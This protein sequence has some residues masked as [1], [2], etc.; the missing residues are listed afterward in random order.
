VVTES[1][2][3]DE[4]QDLDPC[5]YQSD[6]SDSDPHRSEKK[7]PDPRQ[8][9]A[10]PKNRI[11]LWRIAIKMRYTVLVAHKWSADKISNN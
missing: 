6:K 2:Y 8:R 9:D 7:D 1:Y 5:P 11:Q 3:F 4:E 10:N